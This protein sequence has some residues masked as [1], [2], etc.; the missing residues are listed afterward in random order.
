MKTFP[1]PNGQ[2]KINYFPNYNLANVQTKN[3]VIQVK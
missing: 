1:H 3:K 2:T